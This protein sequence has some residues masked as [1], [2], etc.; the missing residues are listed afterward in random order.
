MK[1]PHLKRIGKFRPQIREQIERLKS[2]GSVYITLRPAGGYKGDVLVKI[3]NPKEEEFD[4]S[5][6]LS[7]WTRFPARIR[8]SATEL[9]DQGLMGAFQISHDNGALK[10]KLAEQVARA[11]TTVC[12]DPC[13]R[14]YTLAHQDL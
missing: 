7:D 5:L 4:A 6:D 1:V 10:I 13:L 14:I 3:G 2:S 9:R 12:H 8:A 11:N